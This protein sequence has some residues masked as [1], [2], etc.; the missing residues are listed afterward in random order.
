MLVCYTSAMNNYQP[1]NQNTTTNTN[2]SLP[3]IDFNQFVLK[4]ELKATED[5]LVAYFDAKLEGAITTIMVA[6]DQMIQENRREFAKINQRLD[7][8]EKRLNNHEHAIKDIYK[9]LKIKKANL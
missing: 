9:E 8:I 5:R 3:I 1:I 7:K 6:L 2:Q 4:S